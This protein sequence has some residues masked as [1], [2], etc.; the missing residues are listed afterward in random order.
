MQIQ[1]QALQEQYGFPA[2]Q[3]F[4]KTNIPGVRFFWATQA[5]E[6][7]PL[8]YSSGIV[9][10]GQGYKIGYLGDRVFR[11]DENNYLL[12]G[13]PLPFDC[14]TYATPE[15]PMLGVFIDIDLALLHELVPIVANDLPALEMG[16]HAV[17]RGVEPVELDDEMR[18][19]TERLLRCL[20]S[21]LDSNA[22]GRSL[23]REILYRVFTGPAWTVSLRP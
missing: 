21:P 6:R 19:A 15:T 4:V 11:Y 2:K 10:I 20:I 18:D 8:L 1:L 23:V 13:V 16:S 9:I 14:E 22:L 17:P 5:V 12:L 3:G 7:T